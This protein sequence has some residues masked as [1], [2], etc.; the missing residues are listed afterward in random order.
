MARSEEPSISDIQASRIANDIFA[1]LD[2][3]NILRNFNIFEI[4]T[5]I[6]SLLPKEY[7]MEYKI[8]CDKRKYD[9]RTNLTTIQQSIFSGE[10]VF[11]DSKFNNCVV[12]YWIWTK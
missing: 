3:Q 5:E 12:R 1:L 11:I 8:E 2:Y 7:T 10:R 6:N 9:S 4:N